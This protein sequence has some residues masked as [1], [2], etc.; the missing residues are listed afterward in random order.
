MK[1]NDVIDLLLRQ[2]EEIKGLFD[3]VENAAPEDK[4]EAFQ[5]L[6]RLLAVHETAEEEIVHPYARR[7]ID[8]GEE[9]VDERLAEENAAKDMLTQ[10]EKDGVDHPQFATNLA[11]LRKAVV[12]H[13]E[14]EEHEEFPRFRQATGD[15]ERQ[16]MAVGVKAAE[17][18]APTHPHP[19]VETAAKNLLVGPP[20]AIMDRAR[21]VIRKAMGKPG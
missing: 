6:V 7:K 4:A 14:H 1:D 20:V 12:D 2:H 21:D 5:R 13:A 3:E 10:M 15:K 17:A 19:G 8:H 11:T 9:V 18:M 16:A